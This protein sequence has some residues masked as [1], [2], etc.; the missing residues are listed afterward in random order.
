MFRI[1]GVADTHNGVSVFTDDLH[2]IL[3]GNKLLKCCL[4]Q[5]NAYKDSVLGGLP[6][7]AQNSYLQKSQHLIMAS[8]LPKSFGF[9]LQLPHTPQ[10]LLDKALSFKSLINFHNPAFISRVYVNFNLNDFILSENRHFY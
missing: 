9:L 8:N 7:Y 10:H 6:P 5:V 3:K 4:E 1:N 2:Y